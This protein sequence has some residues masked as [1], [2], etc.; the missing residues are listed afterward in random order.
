MSLPDFPPPALYMGAD[1]LAALSTP[2]L[3]AA[4]SV[5]GVD[6]W[7]WYPAGDDRAAALI[8]QLGFRHHFEAGQGRLQKALQRYREALGAQSPSYLP[9]E[10]CPACLEHLRDA[11]LRAAGADLQDCINLIAGVGGWR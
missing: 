2:G 6:P 4:L 10:L 11:L 5:D 8:L 3:R 7:G 1:E 9:I